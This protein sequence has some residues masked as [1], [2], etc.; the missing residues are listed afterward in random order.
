MP[1]GLT[2]LES[3]EYVLLGVGAATI[4]TAAGIVSARRTWAYWL[5]LPP[6]QEH[7]FTLADVLVGMLGLWV[8]PAAL[9]S[10]FAA[11]TGE[12]PSAAQPASAPAEAVAP[13][14]SGLSA[15]VIGYCVLGGILVL[16]AHA[17]VRGGLAGWGLQVVT[18]RRDAVLAVGA[19]VAVWPVV[20]VLLSGTRR[21]F[22][23]FDSSYS[24]LDHEALQLLRSPESSVLLKGGTILI[25]GVLAPIVEELVCRGLLQTALA[26][27]S[28]SPWAA[29]LFSGAVFGLLHIL[30]PDTVPAMMLFGIVLGYA[31]ARTRSLT[32]AILIHAVLNAK[33][34]AFALLQ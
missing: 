26:R 31:Y 27:W 18:F 34:V 14:V 12:I 5:R 4:L 30:V 11:I 8:L 10:V 32:L 3:V 15:Q 9:W 33:N 7:D 23:W 25:A 24:P 17:R 2:A 29:I 6:P 20:V 22:T 1:L 16:V 21:L 28:G 19:F 13:T